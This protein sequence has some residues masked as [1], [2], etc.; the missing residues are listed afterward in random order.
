MASFGEGPVVFYPGHGLVPTVGA[1]TRAGR[2]PQDT[3]SGK[4]H[5]AKRSTEVSECN[6]QPRPSPPR[7]PRGYRGGNDHP[8]KG[9]NKIQKQ[10]PCQPQGPQEQK[11]TPGR[12][13]RSPGPQG[14]G[15]QRGANNAPRHPGQRRGRKPRVSRDGD[16]IM[17]DA[18]VLNVQPVRQ[19]GISIPHPP[20]QEDVVMRDAFTL[21]PRV[22][23]LLAAL[24][25]AAPQFATSTG[26][27]LHDTEMP[28]APPPDFF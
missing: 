24:T 19:P 11:F 5:R 10:G 16:T 6:K 15:P 18:P 23:D 14:Q 20:P 22:E 25:I 4:T 1:T 2:R 7:G 12:S 17:Y 9:Y 8:T 27:E 26:E 3:G 28:D 21:T 13:R